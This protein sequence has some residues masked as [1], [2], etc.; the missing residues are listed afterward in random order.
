MDRDWDALIVGG[1]FAGLSAAIYLTRN[2][3][4]TLVVDSGH[5]MAVWEPAVQNYLGF[6]EA[7][8]GSALLERGR[9]QAAR[10]GAEFVQDEVLSA[11]VANGS[12]S[13]SSARSNSAGSHS[14]GSHSDGFE[15]LGQIGRY[16]ARRLLIA[17]GLTHLPPEIPGV[18]EC[19]GKSLF[20]CKDCDAFRAQ[21]GRLVIIG[22]NNEAAEYALAMLRF[23]PHVSIALNGQSPHWDA[24]HQAWL[25]EYAISVR[26]ERIVEVQH[27]DGQLR[28]LGFESGGWLAV[29]FAFT[30]RGDVYHTRLA[31]SVGAAL[32]EAGEII[33]DRHMRASVPG[34][35]AA[36]CVTPANCQMVIAA[37]QGAIAG[38]A[39]N[40]DLFEESLR[41]HSLL[42]SEV[43]R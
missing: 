34:L 4:A 13:G 42:G 10:F 40:R 6:P 1:G 12:G 29:D 41:T 18:R 19:L 27:D 20:F 31:K 26:Q 15:V 32:D 28:A 35:Y 30:T 8:S 9:M 21:G 37:G 17:T 2:H 39:I 23:S 38:Q 24:T 7:I 16:R 43:K 14:A 22:R 5:S 36:G 33:V 3:T 25:E 11:R